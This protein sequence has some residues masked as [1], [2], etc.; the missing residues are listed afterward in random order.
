MKA[1]E[2]RRFLQLGLAAGAA[3]A[4]GYGAYALARTHPRHDRMRSRATP[5]A[6]APALVEKR[7]LVV[8]EMAGGNDGLSMIVPYADDHYSKLR[9]RTAIDSD[10]VLRIDDALGFHP[11]L[12]H[13]A[14]RGAAI[15][16]GVGVAKPD[17]S[18]FEMMRR[19]WTA[20]PDGTQNP[21]TGFLGRLCDAIGDPDAAA[22]GVSL[23]YGPSVA[24]NADR[25]TTL[26]MDPAGDGSYPAPGDGDVR[27]RAWGAAQ[28]AM[29]HPDRADTALLANARRGSEL[30]LRFSDVAKRLP[31][32]ARGYPD[33]DL[34]AQ[35]R[36]AARLLAA[37]IGV[38]VVHVPYGADFDT[39]EN[40]T[41]TYPK[42]M[43]D[44]DAALEAFRVD[45]E[46]RKL[47]DAVL[48]ATISEFGRRVPDNGSSGLDHGAASVALLLGPVQPGVYGEPP[49]LAD[50]DENDNLKATVNMT[51]YYATLYE[52]WFGVPADSLLTG[53]P[54]VV[55]GIFA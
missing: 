17:L 15:V 21:Q 1:I 14:T 50:L 18:H 9:E 48:V 7:R 41:G 25:V 37:D 45:L 39:H 51:E 31:R 4:T 40:H 30:A 38:K 24:L 26:S 44:L 13:L 36:L 27:D 12:P 22:V 23:G 54:K 2:R 20:D 52:A 5:P 19:W 53:S 55:P 34:G 28:R 46:Y 8:L 33:T 47:S 43:R 6:L 16:A 32:R 35:L 11:N 3:S 42:L 49:S 29:A 10:T